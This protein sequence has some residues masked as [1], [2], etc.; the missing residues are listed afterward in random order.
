MPTGCGVWPAWWSVGPNWPAGGEIDVIE[1]VNKDTTN[2]YTLHSAEGC[3]LDNSHPTTLLHTGKVL[4]TQ[5]AS[6]GANND[7]CAFVDTD[8]RSFGQ[9][10]ND[11]GGGVYAHLWD[12]TGIKAW[13]FP[14]T[15]IPADIN[16]QNPD[17]STWGPPAAFWS[18]S[19]CDI[20]THFFEHVL[21]FDT[22]LCGDW[23]GGAYSSSGCPGTC[24]QAVSDPSNFASSSRL[25]TVPLT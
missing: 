24:A 21:T 7:G 1:G 5:C 22:T 25:S 13:H 15:N 14:R 18:S 4:N 2:Q 8:A 3:T 17:P 16:A 6:S 9:S 12:S 11:I 19:S 20:A 10:F 23:A